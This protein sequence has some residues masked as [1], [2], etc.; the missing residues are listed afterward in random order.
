MAGELALI[1]HEAV[2]SRAGEGTLPAL[3]ERAGGPAA[4]AWTDFFDGKVR[5]AHTRKAY[6]RSV[7]HFLAWCDGQG[8]ELPRIMA[9]DVGRYLS[10]LSGGAAKKK[11]SHAPNN[12]AKSSLIP[13]F[14]ISRSRL[15]A[16][17]GHGW[18]PRLE[19]LPRQ[20]DGRA[21][22]KEEST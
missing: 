13:D 14:V 12:V 19:S 20:A 16:T 18:K 8:L 10:G 6:L 2:P 21:L 3:V 15:R 4:Q 17:Y 9:G 11:G 1:E 22:G 5:N 7:R